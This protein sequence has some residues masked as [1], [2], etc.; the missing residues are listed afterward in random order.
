M[1]TFLS[2][3]IPKQNLR[4]LHMPDYRTHIAG[5]VA[6]YALLLAIPLYLFGKHFD[7]DITLLAWLLICA[8]A[9][10]LFPDIDIKSK[11][12]MIFGKVA[13]LLI[14][15]GLLLQ[16]WLFLSSLS[17]ILLFPLIV[18]HRSVTHQLWFVLTVPLCMP[19]LAALFSKNFIAPAFWGYLFFAAGAT[20]HILLDFGVVN[21][22]RRGFFGWPKY[23]KRRWKRK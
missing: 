20:S 2:S 15:A 6:A 1:K 13:A 7:L 16:N 14:V 9:G 5:G 19:I 21:S 11:G 10:A 18:H 8:I 17:I 23:R 12:Q 3:T 22:M 4:E